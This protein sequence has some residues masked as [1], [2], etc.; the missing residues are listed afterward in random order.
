MDLKA[1][2][3]KQHDHPNPTL[4]AQSAIN[5]AKVFRMTAND[6]V[7]LQIGNREARR[8]RT[9]EGWGVD[10][11]SLGDVKNTQSWICHYSGDP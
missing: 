8:W 9:N 11:D 4:F 5:Q 10:D 6:F 3:P 2:T 7:K 1:L